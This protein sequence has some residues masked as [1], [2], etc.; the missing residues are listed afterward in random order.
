MATFRQSGH[1]AWPPA[2]RHTARLER[3]ARLTA[4][5]EDKGLSLADLTELTGM[6]RSALAK[7]ETGHLSSRR[8][9]APGRPP[10]DIPPLSGPGPS[11][12]SS[13]TSLAVTRGVASDLPSLSGLKLTYAAVVWY[14]NSTG[15]ETESEPFDSIIWD[16]DDDPDGNVQH[17]AE[18]G[19]TKKEVEE[20]FQSATDADVSRSSGR[21]VGSGTPV[22]ADT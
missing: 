7:L 18:H 11:I 6:D 17:C 4:A 14:Y 5:R 8:P 12:E 2:R 15:Q 10:S 13:H 16:L 20:V 21:P 3:P 19:V 9:A 1:L 22:R